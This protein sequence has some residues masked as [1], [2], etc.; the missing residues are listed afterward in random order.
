MVPRKNGQGGERMNE[1][2]MAELERKRFEGGL[3]EE[4]A[5]ELGRMLAGKPYSNAHDRAHPDSLPASRPSVDQRNAPPEEMPEKEMREAVQE[6]VGEQW[7]TGE[8]RSA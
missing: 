2:R 3:S 6:D 4:E 8:R 5:D 1:A 7:N